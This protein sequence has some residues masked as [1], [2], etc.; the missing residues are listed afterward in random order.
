MPYDPDSSPFNLKN[1]SAYARWRDE[2]L[3]AHPKKLDEIVVHVADP[4]TLTPAERQAVLE[5]VARCN[6][7]LFA[8]SPPDGEGGEVL[9]DLAA[10]LGLREINRHAGSDGHGLSPLTPRPGMPGRFIPYRAQPIKWHTDGY[11]NPMERQVRSLL[12]YCVRNA[13]SG[14]ENRLLDHEI[15]YI[16][17]R[18]RNPAHVAALM[19]SNVMT[20]PPHVDNQ[21]RDV[22]PARSGPVFS[23]TG[24]G[25]LHM[26]YTARTISILW[27]DD[28][29]VALAVEALQAVLANEDEPFAF[30]GTLQPGWGLVCRNVLHTREAFKDPEA[31]LT[32]RLLYRLRCHDRLPDA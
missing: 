11:Y 17:L 29:A 6:M 7:A 28:P 5:R 1:A 10:G 26:R 16:R 18:D 15:A 25:H 31:A 30:R 3:A 2:K 13:G 14:G 23:L 22:R 12:L 4:H 8:S 24:D 21:G 9:L 19:G 27:A 32:K 20:I